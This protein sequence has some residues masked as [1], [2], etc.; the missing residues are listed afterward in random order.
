MKRV[1]CFLAIAIFILATASAQTTSRSDFH[2]AQDIDTTLAAL[3]P[4]SQAAGYASN[5]LFDAGTH[6]LALSVRTKSGGGEAHAHFDDIMIVVDGAA[7]EVTGGTV[8][9]PQTN[10][11]GETHGSSVQGGHAQPL[12]KGDIIHILA[13]TPHQM[14]VAPGGSI[15]YI[16][17]KIKEN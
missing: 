12:A 10:A 6:S 4:Q 3:I 13:G 16:V 5:K 2:S 14:L 9:D 1:P 15:R 8:A 17:V 7:T 11:D